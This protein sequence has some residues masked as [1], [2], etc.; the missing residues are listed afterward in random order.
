M[1]H[2]KQRLPTA[3]VHRLE[4]CRS[5][6]EVSLQQLDHD[7]PL[8][9]PAYR[10]AIA[11][12]PPREVKPALQVMRKYVSNILQHPE[13][14]RCWRIHGTNSV[15]CERL[16]W[17]LA[18]EQLMQSIGFQRVQAS[19]PRGRVAASGTRRQ[20]YLDSDFTLR[21]TAPTASSGF[22]FPTVSKQLL[23]VL[24][25]R[26]VEIQDILTNLPSEPSGA[27]A[28]AKARYS[29]SLTSSRQRSLSPRPS[30]S[31]TT[32]FSRTGTQTPSRRS[33][34]PRQRYGASRSLRR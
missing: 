31:R 17:M 9:H 33:L 21:G 2:P 30:S 4:A 5:D 15:F 13:D 22:T 29:A 12:V 23:R 16:G 20:L 14:Q 34:S 10:E 3:V 24:W 25:R 11:S 6:L 8:V 28:D 7:I 19:Q 26:L 18:S 27:Q 32:R 1:D